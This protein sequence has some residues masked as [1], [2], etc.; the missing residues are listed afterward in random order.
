[1]TDFCPVSFPEEPTPD[2]CK[3]C[4]E[5]G[6]YEHGSRMVWG[7]GNPDAPIMVI[8]DNP[9]LRED[10]EGNEFVCG[11]RQT[12]QQVANNVG[13]NMDD[14]YVTYILK[15]K[16][17]RSYE[18]EWVRE[19]CMIHLS[20]QLQVKQP[21]FILCLGNVAVQSFFKNP[22]VDVKS[23]RGA[24]HDVQGY[25]TMVAYHPLAVRRRPNL[26]GK[27]KEDWTNVANHYRLKGDSPPLR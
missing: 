1:M 13:L 3:E 10:R 23:L 7:E 21:E 5:C 19:T 14:L 12:L 8:L 18:K 2:N 4:R 22:D 15:R 17:T 26:W 20:Q 6:L 11:T 27:F 24:T 9:G 16:P 25:L